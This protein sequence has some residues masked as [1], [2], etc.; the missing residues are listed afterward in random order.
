MVS[1][2]EADQ[3]KIEQGILLALDRL[4]T[5]ENAVLN[6]QTAEKVNTT[7]QA[8]QETIS[9]K[10]D[11]SFTEEFIKNEPPSDSALNTN[12]V[13]YTGSDKTIE[14]HLEESNV[15]SEPVSSAEQEALF[16]QKEKSETTSDEQ[17]AFSP[18]Q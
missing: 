10:E 13:S 15:E 5:V 3:S 1:L 14:N 4:D 2:L 6:T 16:T 8:P 18:E 17:N 11:N 9:N 12:E 7:E